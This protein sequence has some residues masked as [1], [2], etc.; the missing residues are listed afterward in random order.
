MIVNIQHFG[1]KMDPQI[2]GIEA[3]IEEIQKTLKRHRRDKKISYEQQ[4]N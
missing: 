1:N 2:N 4:N 3:Q